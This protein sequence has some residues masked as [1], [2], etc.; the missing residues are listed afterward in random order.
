[1]RGA[2][3]QVRLRLGA[4]G[5]QPGRLD[6]DVDGEVTPGQVAWILFGEDPH[7]GTVQL[8]GVALGPDRALEVAQDRV[9]LEQVRKGRRIRDVVDG[10]DLE[11]AAPKRGAI[12]IAPDPAK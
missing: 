4:L 1:L 6:H 12:H 5:E 9:V 2:Q 11:I 7:A 8:Q 3:V 10:D